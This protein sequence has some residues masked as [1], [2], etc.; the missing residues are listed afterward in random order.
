MESGWTSQI[1]VERLGLSKGA[2]S[3][4]RNGVTRPSLQ[5]LRLYSALSGVPLA[6]PGERPPPNAGVALTDQEKEIVRMVRSF[7]PTQRCAITSM[8]AAIAQAASP[9]SDAVPIAS[10]DPKVREVAKSAI[11]DAVKSVG[12]QPRA[13][14]GDRVAHGADGEKVPKRQRSSGK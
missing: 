14:A 8:L 7:G 13:K 10:D 6:L 3:Q 9:G 12:S 5:V 1:C 2:I 11:E 4:Y